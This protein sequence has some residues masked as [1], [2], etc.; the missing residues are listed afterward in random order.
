MAITP[1]AKAH[2]RRRIRAE[3]KEMPAAD[4]RARSLAICERLI[5]FIRQAGCIALFAPRP[6]EPDLTCLDSAGL[7]SGRTVLFPTLENSTPAFASAK[8][9]AELQRGKFGLLTPIQPASSLEPHLVLVPGLAFSRQ[10]DR[11]GRGAGFYDRY[12][13]A[14]DAAV[15]TVGVAFHLQ[16]IDD[17]PR[18][19]HDVRVRT[20][21][22]EYETV[23]GTW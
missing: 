7:W 23:T 3:L 15:T 9:W 16:L 17:L 8:D 13:A 10:G 4:R 6:D 11:L 1:I 14:L 22:T 2:L 19:A 20:V 18:D 12:L 21:V 5:P